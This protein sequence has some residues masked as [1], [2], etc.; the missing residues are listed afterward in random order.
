MGEGVVMRS[1]V[2]ALLCSMI[3]AWPAYTQSDGKNAN[4]HRQ[5]EI[6]SSRPLT[7]AAPVAVPSEVVTGF[8][9]PLVCDQDGNLYLETDEFGVSGIHKIS[10]KGERLAAFRAGSNPDFRAID[11]SASFALASTGELYELVYPHGQIS[12]YVVVYRSDGSFKSNIKL[13]PGFAW[14]PSKLAVFPN[15]TLLITGQHYD[16]DVVNGMMW[17]FTGIFSPDGVLLKKVELEDDEKLRD[18]TVAGDI[19]LKGSLNPTSNRA[20]SSSQM[21][22]AGDGNIYL[23]RSVTP[24][25]L[26]AVSAGGEVMRRFTVDP[27]DASYRPIAMHVSGGR[28]AVLFS[29]PQTYEKILKIVDLEGKELATYSGDATYLADTTGNVKK[30]RPVGGAFACY[31]TN[32]E[33]FIFLA[34]G[35]DDKL[36][37]RIAEAR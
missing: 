8:R 35:A 6:A 37:F 2:V 7:L 34:T 13:Q 21:E 4:P 11:I 27:G 15:G 1:K 19:R 5:K 14:L 33:R 25:I 23:M 29:E 9:Q 16:K 12:R 20:I 32:P 17:P 24:A 36:E 22:Y 28:V 30:T 26:Y 31:T 18:Q 3:F 10:P